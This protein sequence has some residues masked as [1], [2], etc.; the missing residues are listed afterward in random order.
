MAVPP[1][2]EKI[3]K[4]LKIYIESITRHSLNAHH[5]NFYFVIVCELSTAVE[6]LPAK[7][8]LACQKN[9][10]IFGT[11]SAFQKTMTITIIR[12]YWF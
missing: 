2:S 10:L 6:L 9:S 1:T 12:R 5:L 3:K 7:P 4:R 11:I 8:L